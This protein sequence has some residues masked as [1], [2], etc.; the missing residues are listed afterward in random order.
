M[1]ATSLPKKNKAAEVAMMAATTAI[2]ATTRLVPLSQPRG[3]C[4]H[5]ELAAVQT[6]TCSCAI[7]L[8][9]RRLA[10]EATLI[11]RNS[12]SMHKLDV[13]K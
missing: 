6:T 5:L 9:K 1:N 12:G 8:E 11:A 13:L 10:D 2:T 3:S 4:P 7:H